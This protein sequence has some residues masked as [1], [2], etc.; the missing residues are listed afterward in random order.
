M[1]INVTGSVYYYEERY[2]ASVLVVGQKPV[3]LVTFLAFGRL[4]AA[5]GWS[6]LYTVCLPSEWLGCLTWVF[7]LVGKSN[8][9]S[10]HCLVY[11]NSV[12]V[13]GFC[14]DRQL[15]IFWVAV[16]NFPGC[17]GFQKRKTTSCRHVAP[18]CNGQRCGLCGSVWYCASW[19]QGL[20]ER[21]LYRLSLCQLGVK[22]CEN[23]TFGIWKGANV[24]RTV[25]LVSGTV[26][27]SAEVGWGFI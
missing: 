9:A 1:D 4:R 18:A 16:W 21:V 3:N 7:K 27:V 22:G 15:G 14:G 12:K 25:P 10:G 24:A 13:V 17:S 23:I 8:T 6:R 5:V 26:E 20:A 19:C 11:I 2:V